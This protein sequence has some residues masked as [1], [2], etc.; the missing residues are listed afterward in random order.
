MN[1]NINIADLEQVPM[2]NI[3]IFM[4][5]C[6]VFA[7]VWRFAD[8]LAAMMNQWNFSYLNW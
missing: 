2:M 6:V 4:C 7:F 1:F 5:G 3:A 8:N